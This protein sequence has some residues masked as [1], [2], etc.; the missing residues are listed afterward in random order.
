MITFT[1]YYTGYLTI[2]AKEKK[3]LAP[4]QTD[5]WKILVKRLKLM[6]NVHSESGASNSF[7]LYREN[8]ILR[9]T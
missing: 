6:E 8:V 1:N 7:S 3:V 5:E 2:K 4:N 9:I